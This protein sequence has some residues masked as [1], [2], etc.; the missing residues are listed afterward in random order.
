MW[1]QV[2]LHS[3]RSR[4]H[5]RRSLS[6]IECV[7]ELPQEYVLLENKLDKVKAMYE[8]FLRL[9]RS[10]SHSDYDPSIAESVNVAVGKL[11]ELVGRRPSAD[12]V[13]SPRPVA[14][15]VH[16]RAQTGEEV[17][18][19]TLAHAFARASQATAIQLGEHEPLGAA[20]NKLSHSHDRIGNARLKMETDV[21]ARFVQPWS[22]ALN[23]N[24]Q[25]AVKA[26]KVLAQARLAFDQAKM[27]LKNAKPDKLAHAQ[28]EL[29]H[30]EEAFNT[31]LKDAQYKIRLVVE[32]PEILRNLSDL[33][34]AQLAFY[35]EAFEALS[36]LAPEIDELQV[37][38][39]ALF[40][41]AQ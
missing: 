9:S 5:R 6:I 7:T 21:N 3:H 35:K 39:E 18:P 38:Q 36:E 12:E 31:A 20:L 30:A 17:V 4:S 10:F 16:Q 26:K 13:P 34:N 33:V 40:R 25:F 41:N 15:G 11:N 23:S 22:A 2:P 28:E 14:N 8:T 19:R 24:V 32:S 27:K 37:T 1:I 29:A